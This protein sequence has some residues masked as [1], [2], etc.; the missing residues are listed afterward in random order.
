M[1]F[2]PGGAED[3]YFE[4]DDEFYLGS[5][6][7]LNFNVNKSSDNKANQPFKKIENGQS[8]G[9][10]GFGSPAAKTEKKKIVKPQQNRSA[11][12]KLGIDDFRMAI[13]RGNIDI[14]KESVNQGFDINCV[15]KC[16]W[17][18]LMYAANSAHKDIVEFLVAQGAN[19]KCHH[20]MFNA[21]MAACSSTVNNQDD[22]RTCVAHLIE[23]GSDVNSHDRYHMTPLIYAA[24]EG[25]DQVVKYLLDHGANINKQ[26]SRGWSALSWSVSKNFVRVGKVLIDRGVDVN[27]KHCDGQTPLDLAVI[28]QYDEIISLLGGSSS[29][30]TGLPRPVP[31]MM[32]NNVSTLNKESEDEDN[33]QS[34]IKYGELEL[35]LCGLDLSQ[36]VGL[37]Q[38][39]HLDFTTV[40]RMN[41]EDL[42]KMGIDQIG[43]RKKIL[44]GIRIVHKKEWETSSLQQIQY[45][46]QLSCA[47][48]I[49]MVANISKHCKYIG[50]TCGYI[51]DQ[52]LKHKDILDTQ[53]GTGPDLLLQHTEDSMKNVQ[54]LHKE[55]ERLARTLNTQLKRKDYSPPDLVISKKK[56]SG[57]KKRR[58]LAVSSVLIT[59]G[60]V[61][62]KQ[63]SITEYFSSVT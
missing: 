9:R 11:P 3:D 1:E 35:F 22:V 44:D 21:L 7:E 57:F 39:H 13:T 20:D 63:K 47:D 18:G 42:I 27:L 6:P 60:L 19:V 34:V 50:N 31:P 62:W 51:R 17:T 38:Q 48:T 37:F 28:Q 61:W 52:I 43:V 45:N 55:L 32:L 5:E 25:K 29:S 30:N 53:D 15:L 49:A 54:G 2:Y 33:S 24:R 14:V 56:K 40:L 41:D 16:G 4:S 26:D 23:A 12:K 36:Y 8:F 58:L 10:G 46:K 59:V